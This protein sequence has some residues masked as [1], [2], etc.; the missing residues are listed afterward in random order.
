MEHGPHQD[1]TELR[2][3]LRQIRVLKRE[4]VGEALETLELQYNGFRS[5]QIL[6]NLFRKDLK[7][8]DMNQMAV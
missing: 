4:A 7:G 1:L 5:S 8:F 6:S 2:Q 3:E